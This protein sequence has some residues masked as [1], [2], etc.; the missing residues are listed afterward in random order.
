MAIAVTATYSRGRVDLIRS[1]IDVAETK[2]CQYEHTLARLVGEGEEEI[3][4][5]HAR[6]FTALAA[7]STCA[8]T[9]LLD[10]SVKSASQVAALH[11]CSCVR[12]RM[13]EPC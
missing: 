4:L 3:I 5:E 1:C 2:L 6:I 13:K 12:V 10:V 9:N 8:T 11:V 7:G